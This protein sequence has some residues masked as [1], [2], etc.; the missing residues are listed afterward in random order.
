MFQNKSNYYKTKLDNN[1][2][3][4]EESAI[5]LIIDVLINLVKVCN[6]C[7]L[8]FQF[9]DSY[10]Q[11]IKSLT[12]GTPLSGLFANFHVDILE[13]GHIIC[14][15]LSICLGD[16]SWTMLWHFGIIV[17]IHFKVFLTLELAHLY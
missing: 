8:H 1:Y 9:H 11:Q 17:K 15:F 12:I 5:G 6:R 10:Y 7:S 13:I 4:I 14:I 3:L 16:V 2:H